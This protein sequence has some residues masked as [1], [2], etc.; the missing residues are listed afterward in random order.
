M[1]YNLILKDTLTLSEIIS[2]TNFIRLWR[3][4]E[5][6][7]SFSPLFGNVFNYEVGNV[8]KIEATCFL[9][10]EEVNIVKI[11]FQKDNNTNST[12]LAEINFD[13]GLSISKVEEYVLRLIITQSQEVKFDLVPKF[14]TIGISE[15][16]IDGDPFTNALSFSKTAEELKSIKIPNC[17]VNNPYDLFHQTNS[18]ISIST[19]NL[20]SNKSNYLRLDLPNQVKIPNVYPA[21]N[22]RY[23]H[24]NGKLFCYRENSEGKLECIISDELDKDLMARC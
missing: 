20:Q 15:N 14:E 13:I 21:F 16:L 9:N 10:L 24:L 1:K 2:K 18:P 7:N 8:S 3:D 17:N 6:K 4:G 22:L 23:D 12:S 5:I 11:S 19:F